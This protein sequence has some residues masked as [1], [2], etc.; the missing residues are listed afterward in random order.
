MPVQAEDKDVKWD[1]LVH[2]GVLFP[3]D[4]TSHGIKMLYDGKPVDLTLEQEEVFFIPLLQSPGRVLQ[5]FR[6]PAARPYG[7]DIAHR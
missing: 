6:W 4:Y 7:A 3:P 2:S 5:I 1:T